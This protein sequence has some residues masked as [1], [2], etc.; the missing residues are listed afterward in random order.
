MDI[1]PTLEVMKSLLNIS[2]QSVETAIV[3]MRKNKKYI[4]M[5]NKKLF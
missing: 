2:Q 1:P 4:N 5:I 3:L